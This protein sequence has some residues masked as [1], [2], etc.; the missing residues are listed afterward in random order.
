MNTPVPIA[1]L[2]QEACV[3]EICEHGVTRFAF[4][5]EQTSGLRSRDEETGHLVE[6]VTNARS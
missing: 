1:I 3:H 6:L 2:G 5:A 4:H